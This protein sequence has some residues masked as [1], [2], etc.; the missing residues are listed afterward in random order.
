MAKPMYEPGDYVRVKAN[1]GTSCPGIGAVA[2]VLAI[3]GDQYMR[4]QFDPPY[5][6]LV[7]KTALFGGLDKWFEGIG[8]GPW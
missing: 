3:Q 2:R 5:D 1:W 8:R 4:I 6:K 7:D